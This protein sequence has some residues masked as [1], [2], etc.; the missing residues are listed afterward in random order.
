[1][2]FSYGFTI[3]T[4]E[5]TIFYVFIGWYAFYFLR[6]V[7][8]SVCAQWLLLD[9]W[10]CLLPQIHAESSFLSVSTAS[11]AKCCLLMEIYRSRHN[12]KVTILHNMESLRT[13]HS[14]SSTHS[15]SILQFVEH[16]VD[17]RGHILLLSTHGLVKKTTYSLT[18]RLTD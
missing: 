12:L 4:T 5:H 7:C 2:I 17:W 6:I 15:K 10:C 9:K 3:P 1:M 8:L 13:G 14:W 11:G 18:K 16:N